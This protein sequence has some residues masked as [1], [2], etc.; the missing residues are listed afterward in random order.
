MEATRE[1]EGVKDLV[2]VLGGLG[3][4][5]TE[6]RSAGDERRFDAILRVGTRRVLVE[7]K[8]DVRDGD[9]QQL[10]DSMPSDSIVVADRF[11][12]RA[13][14]LLDRR[15]IG[16]LDRRGHLRLILPPG[17]FIDKEVEP[18]VVEAQG[19]AAN[20]FTPVGLD[21]AIAVLLEPSRALGVREI[22]RRTGASVGRISELLRELRRQ[23]VVN[24]DGTPAI[25]D[26]FEAIVDAWDPKWV[27]LGGTPPPDSTLR[28]AGLQAAIWHGVPLAVTEGWPPE[29]YLRDKFALRRLVRTYPPD[30]EETISPVAK[31]AVCPSLYGFDQARET[32]LEFPVVNHVVVAL[33]LAQDQG[34]GR[35]ALEQWNPESSVRVW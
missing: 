10:A 20:P 12:P 22:S 35:E 13:R 33:D 21:V 8:R 30:L 25:P 17:I 4:E 27:A 31:V 32:E 3:L 34:R 14:T 1:S 7:V 23:G 19:R 18:L 26:L 5:A 28:L 6:I 29:L 9:A 2:R 24:R 15:Q 11:S 16:W